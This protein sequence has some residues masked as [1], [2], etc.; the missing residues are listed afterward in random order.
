[1]KMLLGKSALEGCKAVRVT[2]LFS[3]GNG[4]SGRSWQMLL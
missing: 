4:I 3:L 2:C 1:M